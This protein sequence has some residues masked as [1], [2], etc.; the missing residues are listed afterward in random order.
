[1]H[2]ARCNGL[3]V[4]DQLMDFEG[5]GS[6]MWQVAWRCVNCGCIWDAL[7]EENYRQHQV[8]VRQTTNAVV[9]EVAHEVTHA[10]HT[11]QPTDS[12]AS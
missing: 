5:T 6:Y 8:T 9:S 11:E 3:M 10:Y 7:T 1:M 4:T 12:T 2:C